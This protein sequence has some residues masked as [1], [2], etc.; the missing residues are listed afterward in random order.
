MQELDTPDQD[1]LP[2]RHRAPGSAGGRV[3]LR[4]CRAALSVLLVAGLGVATADVLGLTDLG[5]PAAEAWPQQRIPST[6]EEEPRPGRTIDLS[7]RPAPADP[8][9]AVPPAEPSPEGE[10]AVAVAPVQRAAPASQ[11]PPA[12]VARVRTGD[13]CPVVGRTAVTGRGDAAVCT[14]S[15]G[16]GPNKWRAA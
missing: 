9:P 3:S 12:P 13:V 2:G 5:Q 7:D 6:P 4:L 10:P 8:E 1:D 14:A 11:P 16:N 15:P